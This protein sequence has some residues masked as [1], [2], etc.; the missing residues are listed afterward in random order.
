[1]DSVISIVSINNIICI[2]PFIN[3]LIFWMA[4]FVDSTS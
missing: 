3:V 1:L 4:I 2:M